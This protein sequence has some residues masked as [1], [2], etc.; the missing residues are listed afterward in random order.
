M[1]ENS[2]DLYSVSIDNITL[3][4]NDGRVTVDLTPF[5]LS[6]NIIENIHS[7]FI[8]CHLT[9]IDFESVSSKFPLVGQEYLI[10]NYTKKRSLSDNN[11][12]SRYT[13]IVYSQTQGG[14]AENNRLQGY[15][16]HG[17]TVERFIDKSLTF[18]KS[19]HSSYGVMVDTIFND[20]FKSL[21]KPIEVEPTKGIQKFI[22]PFSSPLEAIELIRKRSLSVQ[23][24]YTPY[25]F[26]QTREKFV[27]AS[28]NTLFSNAIL[29]PKANIA[30]YYVNTLPDD[31]NRLPSP[32]ARNVVGDNALND[33][34]SL[35]ILDKY[36]S[37]RSMDNNA[38]SSLSSSFDLTTKSFIR[39]QYN[40]S[41]KKDQ[42]FLGNKGLPLSQTFT[43]NFEN[44]GSSGPYEITD[45]IGR[46]TDG[47]SQDFLPDAISSMTSYLHT[48][49]QERIVLNLYGDNSY[50]PGDAIYLGITD[51]DGKLDPTLSGYH[52]ITAVR[53][54]ITIDSVPRYVVSL[55]CFKGS[56][57]KTVD[58][59]QNG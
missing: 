53:H 3:V 10:V 18:S 40:I 23:E 49:S 14:I 34:L 13:F 39:R 45:V 26:F 33:I 58:N 2:S 11:R 5:V 42:F 22:V 37:L 55:E 21:N 41:D 47:S 57:L 9:V 15:N 7:P 48:A 27:F 52:F 28:Y 4:S 24:P 19:F 16:L 12:Q 50:M 6:I 8:S 44:V 36:N 30:H 31:Q 43:D 54:M 20:Y 32:I 46:Y 59:M 1:S 51:V 56:Y 29:N 35:S 17:V 25:L 38:Y